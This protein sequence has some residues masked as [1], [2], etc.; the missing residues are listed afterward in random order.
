MYLLDDRFST[1]VA[2]VEGF[3]A[4]HDENPLNGFQ[5][6]VCRRMVGGYS[7]RHWAYVLASAQ[8]PGM[9]DGNMSIDRIPHELENGLI[10]MMLDL[11]EEFSNRP[12]S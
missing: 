6:W 4:A 9:A 2:F 10:E 5:E 11:L 7:S 3:S 12:V 1:A 8:V